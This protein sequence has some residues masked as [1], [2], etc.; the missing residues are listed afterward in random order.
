[1]G[2]LADCAGKIGTEK[3]EYFP[4]FSTFVN[5]GY[6]DYIPTPEEAAEAKEQAEL[7][8]ASMDRFRQGFKED[9]ASGKAFLPPRGDA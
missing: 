2:A 5:G 3:A 1:M 7:K 8:A 4:H 6:E 9:M